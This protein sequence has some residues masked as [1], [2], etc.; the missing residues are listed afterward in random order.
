MP[1]PGRLSPA[2]GPVSGRIGPLPVAPVSRPHSPVAY[3]G[4]PASVPPHQGL[5]RYPSAPVSRPIETVP[6]SAAPEAAGPGT[7]GPGTSSRSATVAGLLQMFL[8]PVAAGRFYTG[9]VGM[10][11]AQIAVGWGVLAIGVC[12][13]VA[14]V[15]PLLFFWVGFLWPFIDGVVLLGGGKDADGNELR[16]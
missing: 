5:A 3:P 1:E 11:V 2:V 4:L 12:L 6:G 14:L 15:V 7:P 10:A 13:G 8:G 9:H 16:R